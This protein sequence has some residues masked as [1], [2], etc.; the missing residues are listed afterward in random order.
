[1]YLASPLRLKKGTYIASNDNPICIMQV[2]LYD[3]P[4]TV[5]ASVTNNEVT[6]TLTKDTDVTVRLS[7]PGGNTLS[8]GIAYPMIRSSSVSDSTYEK[9]VPS[10]STLSYKKANND[11]LSDA[12]NASTTYAVDKYCI[13]NNSLWKCLVQNKGQTPKAGT[14]WTKVTVANEITSVNNDIG[15][16]SGFTNTDYYSIGSFLQY[17]VDNGYLP[18]INNIPLIPIM[19]SNTTP[20]GV[21]SSS[22]I[23]S[24]F[25]TYLAFDNN[26]STFWS[27]DKN[28]VPAWIKYKFPNKVCVRKAKIKPYKDGGGTHCKD[29]VIQGSN[30]DSNWTNLYSGTNSNGSNA[31][32]V[33]NFANSN[34]YQYYRCYMPNSYTIYCALVSLQLY[35]Y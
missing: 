22:S 8:N 20:S 31:D 32:I 16:I 11:I 15:D 28:G 2:Y 33:V 35:G 6:F 18:D 19:T 1:M 13:Y 12:W 9:Y 34:K 21:A 4:H 3:T 26:D 10:N 7:I 25:Y 5:F 27:S 29:F 23:N 17:C 24:K 14:Y 30:D